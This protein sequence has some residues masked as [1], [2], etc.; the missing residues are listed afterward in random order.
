[1]TRLPQKPVESKGHG[2]ETSFSPGSPLR[3]RAE[4]AVRIVVGFDGEGAVKARTA[5][6]PGD[7]GAQLGQLAFGV[8]RAQS[9]V[10]R[11]GN[12]GGSAR[13]GDGQL[14]GELF[15]FI[16]PDAGLKL[17][18]IAK[19]FFANACFSADGR[20][21]VDSKRATDQHSD[22]Q[23]CEF[24]DGRGQEALGCR[25]HVHFHAG[26]EQLGVERANSQSRRDAPQMTLRK[27]E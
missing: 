22:F 9:L 24:L 17:R 18:E 2:P 16:E 11:V 14:Q 5:V 1:M 23:L 26:A 19:F 10:E 15:A 6:L 13:Q 27:P 7:D 12:V 20:M 8:L 4:L 3:E 25:V 21:D